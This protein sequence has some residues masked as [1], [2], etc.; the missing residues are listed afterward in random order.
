MHAGLIMLAS[1]SVEGRLFM[2]M[3]QAVTSVCQAGLHLLLFLQSY[4]GW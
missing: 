3:L 4:H 2:Q 1:K